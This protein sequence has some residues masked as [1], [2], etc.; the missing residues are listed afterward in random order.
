MSITNDLQIATFSR[1]CKSD[2]VKSKKTAMNIQVKIVS[3]QKRF[4]ILEKL[5]SRELSPDEATAV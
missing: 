3:L 5:R 1:G 4:S 2:S